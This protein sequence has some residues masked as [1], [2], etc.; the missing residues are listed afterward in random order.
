MSAVAVEAE[1]S[2]IELVGRLLMLWTASPTEIVI[3]RGDVW[4]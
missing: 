1:V 2:W 3:L 4:K